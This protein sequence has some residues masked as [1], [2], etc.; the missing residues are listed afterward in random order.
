M[1][2]L[3]RQPRHAD[4]RARVKR[5]DP[6]FYRWGER[7]SMRDA[8]VKRP[9]GS[10]LMGFGWAYL[11]VAVGTNRGLL[12]SSLRQGT[13]SA[14]TQNWVL[15]GLASLLAISGVML[16]IHL[17]RYFFHSGG[18]KQNSGAMLIGVLG[19]LVL[20]YTPDS[21]WN[22]GLGMMDNNSRSMLLTASA[23]F[24]DALPGVDLGAVAFVS[25]IG[26]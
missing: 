24:E 15:M 21:V 7:G 20:V 12:E 9:F 2:S 26:K 3:V 22:T 13:L 10:V 5:V 16:C 1:R 14:E 4:F 17:F 18:K 6:V 23:T 25:S 8:T 19:A 11:V